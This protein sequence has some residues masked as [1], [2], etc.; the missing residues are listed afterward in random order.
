MADNGV[1]LVR[2]HVF[3]LWPFTVDSSAPLICPEKIIDILINKL[4]SLLGLL[5][6]S[7]KFSIVLSRGG[8]LP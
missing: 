4:S 5:I 3:F 2:L 6:N 7:D 8:E 1:K